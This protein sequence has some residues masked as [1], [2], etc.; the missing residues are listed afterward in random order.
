[1]KL[2]SILLPLLA[3]STSYC[4]SLEHRLSIRAENPSDDAVLNIYSEECR[5]AIKENKD[6]YSCAFLHFSLENREEGCKTYFSD[7]CQTILKDLITPVPACKND[8]VFM[9]RVSKQI[10]IDNSNSAMKFYC[11][12]DGDGKICPGAEIL[13]KGQSVTNKNIEQNCASKKCLNGMI[14]YLKFK[15]DNA[16]RLCEAKIVNGDCLEYKTVMDHMIALVDNKECSA[17]AKDDTKTDADGNTANNNAS[18]GANSIK[19]NVTLLA[20]AF[21]YIFI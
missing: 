13:I 7:T 3:V 19:V 5:N 1:M 16:D 21:L 20:L 6:Y 2:T 15:I 18:S 9:E 14:D 8:P 10:N 11:T 12:N 4:Y 17:K